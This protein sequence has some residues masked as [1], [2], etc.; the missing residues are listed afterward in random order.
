[1]RI[2]RNYVVENLIIT[3][4]NDRDT[5]EKVRVAIVKQLEGENLTRERKRIILRYAVRESHESIVWDEEIDVTWFELIHHLRESI[6]AEFYHNHKLID[7]VFDKLL[8]DSKPF[9]EKRPTLEELRGEIDQHLTN[10]EEA[11]NKFEFK[12]NEA[13]L[14]AQL[15]NT[16]VKT[17]TYVYGVDVDTLT[18]EQ[19][20]ANIKRAKKEIA[21]LESA[22]VESKFIASQVKSI[23]DAVA[24]MVEKLDADQ[25]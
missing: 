18:K 8:E 11:L 3:A 1:M 6:I 22:G 7:Q 25:A 16:P 21:D 9:G 15:Q 20:I 19:L 17:I 13:L 24:L 4:V 5:Y 14:M 2:A 10:A 12:H 23:N